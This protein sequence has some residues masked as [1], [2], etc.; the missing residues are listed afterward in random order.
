MCSIKQNAANSPLLRLP[1]EVRDKIWRYAVGDRFIHVA[2]DKPLKFRHEICYAPVTEQEAHHLFHDLEYEQQ[3]QTR[4]T[5]DD[6]RVFF[7]RHRDC[8][9]QA[10]G[11]RHLHVEALQICRQVYV[12][13][14]PILW[15]TNTWSFEESYYLPKWLDLRNATQRR[16]LAKLHMHG[17]IYTV[18]IKKSLIPKFPALEKLT[19]DLNSNV[20]IEYWRTDDCKSRRSIYEK[21]LLIRVAS[22]F[23]RAKN[24]Q[25]IYSGATTAMSSFAPRYFGPGNPIG[26]CIMESKV[27]IDTMIQKEERFA[28]L[29]TQKRVSKKVLDDGFVKEP[30]VDFGPEPYINP[31]IARKRKA[32]TGSMQQDIIVI[33]DDEDDVQ[34]TDFQGLNLST[35]GSDGLDGGKRKLVGDGETT[36]DVYEDEAG[37][38]KK[39]KKVTGDFK[40]QSSTESGDLQEE[41]A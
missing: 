38:V 13:M 31:S 16:S 33:D 15:A 24:V 9:K 29:Q 4:H 41:D 19:L 1:R 6:M 20:D 14:N 17:S 22:F 37:A 32:L 36:D 40:A 18:Q 25:I 5:S 23:L 27:I 34:V 12:E 39:K 3:A 35:G 10:V 28:N 11:P 26:R 2:M 7:N 21:H 8:Y 30:K